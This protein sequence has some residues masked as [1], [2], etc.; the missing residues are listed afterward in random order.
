MGEQRNYQPGKWKNI[1]API[2]ETV[3]TITSKPWPY[4]HITH[5]AHIRQ[6]KL[7]S[8]MILLSQS[9][10]PLEQLVLRLSLNSDIH[11]HGM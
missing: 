6:G 9:S 7:D 4:L 2:L 8:C 11:N 10:S 3:A 1:Y 5:D